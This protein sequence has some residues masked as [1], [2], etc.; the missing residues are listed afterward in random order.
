MK[1]TKLNS[2]YRRSEFL[3]LLTLGGSATAIGA[4]QAQ[5]AI[6]TPSAS[7]DFDEGNLRAFIELARSDLRSQ[8]AL[9]VS[10]NIEFTNDEAAE[11]WPL[12]REYDLEVNRLLDRRFALIKEYAANFRNMTDKTAERLIKQAFDFDEDRID[13]KRK[14]FKKMSKVASV[15]KVARFFQLDNQLSMVVD[16]QV[17]AALP[18]IE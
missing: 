13:L 4:L 18:L 2:T 6:P 3:R 10:Q 9:I 17:A 1:T 11:F 8:K 5:E 16:L 12:H 14:Y 7:P 15:V